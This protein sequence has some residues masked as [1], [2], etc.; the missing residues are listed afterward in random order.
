M[1]KRA[2]EL[3]AELLLLADVIERASK[4][5]RWRQIA[6]IHSLETFKALVTYMSGEVL[7]YASWELRSNREAV[8]WA[9]RN[10][11]AALEF[12]SRE[13]RDDF[14]VVEAAVH[15]YGGALTFASERLKDDAY[16]LCLAIDDDAGYGWIGTERARNQ[17]RAEDRILP[18][19]TAGA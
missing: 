14:M 6:R 1:S 19:V 13:L 10:D 4:D 17:L 2:P 15:Q 8:L 11:G 5:P 16:L 18:V 3:A 9:V 12:A 7:A